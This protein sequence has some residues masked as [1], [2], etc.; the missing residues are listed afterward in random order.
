M[1]KCRFDKYRIKI[2]E[3]KKEIV[4]EDEDEY[5]QFY[6]LYGYEPD[7][8][9]KETQ[10]KSTKVLKKRKLNE[11]LDDVDVKLSRQEKVRKKLKY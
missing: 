8:Q 4:F 11:W 7:E 3:E 5:E 10:E 9:N 6:E 2:E 1:W